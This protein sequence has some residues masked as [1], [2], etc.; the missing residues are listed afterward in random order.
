V[1]VSV[2]AFVI[3]CHRLA[4]LER[5]ALRAHV[6]GSGPCHTPPPVVG[7]REPWR[8]PGLFLAPLLPQSAFPSSSGSRAMLMAM[9]RAS[10]A[11]ST[12]ACIAGCRLSTAR[13][14]S[15][16]D[17][18]RGRGILIEPRD[19]LEGR[20]APAGR[21]MIHVLRAWGYSLR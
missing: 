11:V 8:E 4:G 13:I 19:P 12:L 20:G 7:A 1:R 21:T 15:K 17:L 16:S 2:Q 10:S 6:I 3:L 18:A 5:R 14:A 9:R